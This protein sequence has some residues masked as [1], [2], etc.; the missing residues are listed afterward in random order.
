MKAVRGGPPWGSRGCIGRAIRLVASCRPFLLIG[1]PP[2][3]DWRGLNV[4]ANRPRMGKLEVA[5]RAAAAR[6]HL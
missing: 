4:R 1:S 3:A 5:K 6:A 2:R